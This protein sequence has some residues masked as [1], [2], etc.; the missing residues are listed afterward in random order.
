MIMLR[1]DIDMTRPQTMNNL[2]T[3]LYM[4]LNM[5]ITFAGIR[6]WFDMSGIE[7]DDVSLF[8]SL[9]FPEQLTPEKKAEFSRIIYY[10]YEDVFF[11]VN[12]HEFSPT[13]DTDNLHMNEPIHQLLLQMMNIRS[14]RGCDNA[15][16]DLGVAISQDK[17]L[18]RPLWPS[19]HTLFQVS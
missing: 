14:L 18:E 4:M 13:D 17:L 5:E 16:I 15:L 19:I 1:G 3:E 7:I 9:L 2:F 6:N 11:Q 8:K 10:R 12:R